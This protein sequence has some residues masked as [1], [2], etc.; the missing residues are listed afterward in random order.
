MCKWISYKNGGTLG[1]Q[2][3]QGGV[4]VFDEELADHCRLTVEKMSDGSYIRICDIYAVSFRFSFF[5]DEVKALESCEELKKDMAEWIYLHPNGVG[6][7]GWSVFFEE[8]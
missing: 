7:I 4:I 1:E 8:C 5:T 6:E 3:L 2:G